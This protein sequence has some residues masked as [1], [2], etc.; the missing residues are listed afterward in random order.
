[1]SLRGLKINR[2]PRRSGRAIARL[3]EFLGNKVIQN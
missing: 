2:M 3:N 1:M